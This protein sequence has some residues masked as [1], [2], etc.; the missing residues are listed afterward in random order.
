LQYLYIENHCEELKP[1][2]KLEIAFE[3][4]E[5]QFSIAMGGAKS[6]EKIEEISDIFIKQNRLTILSNCLVLLAKK[7]DDEI[8]QI[9]IKNGFRYLEETREENLRTLKGELNNL[10]RKL[11]G[12]KESIEEEAKDSSK[13][14]LFDIVSKIEGFKQI[15]IDVHTLTTSQF[16]AYI[17]EIQEQSKKSK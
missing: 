3:K 2:K 14:S 13:L 12:K 11:H 1:N 10:Y 6:I 15:S 17:K 9:V 16:I 8:A 7:H 4:I 5:E